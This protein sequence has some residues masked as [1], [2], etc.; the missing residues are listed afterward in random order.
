MFCRR[1]PQIS[2]VNRGVI[3]TQPPHQ[4]N[5]YREQGEELLMTKTDHLV[6]CAVAARLLKLKSASTHKV[7]QLLGS[8]IVYW[9]T[10]TQ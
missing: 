8:L 2:K 3:Q 1:S 7:K 10:T 9:L 6:P 5:N 4:R